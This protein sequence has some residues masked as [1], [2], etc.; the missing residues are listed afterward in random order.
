MARCP[1]VAGESAD[2]PEIVAA[3]YNL[4][5]DCVGEVR[6][7]DIV[8]GNAVVPGDVIIGI[9]SSGMHTNGA[10][11]LRK[12]LF[13]KWGGKFDLFA[14]PDGFEKELVFEALTPTNIYVDEILELMSKIDVRGAVHITGDAYIKFDKI[15]AFSPGIGFEFRNF[16]PQEIFS[17]IQKTG[18][19]EDKE[20]LSTFNMGWGFAVIVKKEDADA[21]LDILNR[22]KESE[23]IGS[24]TG[25]GRIT[26]DFNGRKIL[27]K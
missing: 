22:H 4:T 8:K 3:D 25:T 19:I 1:M 13:R 24:V 21:T 9:R 5:C 23:V 27:L 16:R 6:E 11:L 10:S 12:S 14:K 2:V 15:F 7:K 26:A 18:N 20:M 17:L